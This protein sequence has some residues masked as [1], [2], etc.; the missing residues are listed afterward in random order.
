MGTM[1]HEQFDKGKGPET[2]Q[3]K[4]APAGA[5]AFGGEARPG[6]DPKSADIKAEKK[7]EAGELAALRSRV[8]EL[9]KAKA[10]SEKEIADLKVQLAQSGDK[11]LRAMAD[12]ENQRKRLQRQREEDMKYANEGLL[13]DLIKVMDDFERA[14]ASSDQSKD[15]K[16]LYDGVSMIRSNF[17]GLFGKYGA[18]KYEAK[19]E[20]FDPNLHE[21][22]AS[23]PGQVE[24]PMVSEVYQPG[25]KLHDRVLRHARVKVKMPAP[26]ADAAAAAAGGTNSSDSG[27]KDDDGTKAQ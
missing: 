12:G 9:E 6:P 27:K 19:G 2:E 22:V 8:E 1:H 3:Q 7:A 21:A 25:Y 18:E 24:E 11:Y 23:E 26:K 17:A 14:L 10:A 20:P 15:Y 16:V 4:A 13:K 5:K